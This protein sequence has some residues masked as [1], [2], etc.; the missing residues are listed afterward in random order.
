MVNLLWIFVMSII[1]QYSKIQLDMKK[2]FT[3]IILISILISNSSCSKDCGFALADL[4]TELAFSGVV[5]VTAG[6]PFNIPN[7]ISNVINTVER[8]NDNV[9]ETLGAGESKSRLLVDFDTQNNGSFASTQL[10]NNFTVPSISSGA[11]AEENYSFSFDEPGD[12]RVITFADDSDDVDER[13]EN[14]NASA[15]EILPAG[16]VTEIGATPVD[17]TLIIR[18]LPNPNFQRKKGAPL[19]RLLSRTVKIID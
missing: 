19:V 6:V 9:K 3:L 7:A 15:P 10:N 18:V 8:C 5:T 12:Y 13:M 1:Q 11:T 2:V 14:N 17:E 16:R 4:V